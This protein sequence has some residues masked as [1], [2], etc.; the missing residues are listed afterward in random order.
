MQLKA[1]S[2]F[3]VL[4]MLLFGCAQPDKNVVNILNN[5]PI[6]NI[7]HAGSGFN[8]LM[9]PFNPLPP[10]SFA[11]LTNALKNGAQGVEVDLQI[12]SDNKLVLFHDKTT[13]NAGLTG[14]VPSV[15]SSELE[16]ASYK[17]GFPYDIF[18]DEKVI[19]FK[20]WISYAVKL[21][22]IPYLQIDVKISEGQSDESK[23]NLLQN[24]NR[25]LKEVSYPLNKVIVISGDQLMLKKLNEINPALELAFEPGE[26]ENG[27]KWA[28]ENNCKYLILDNRLLTSEKVKQSHEQGI[29]VI[30][31]G[32]KARSTL[33][34]VINMKPMFI[35][36]NHVGLVNELLQ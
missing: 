3:L 14:T 8:Y 15:N 26:F 27:L 7:G 36:S 16:G 13:E 4:L 30:A 1:K 23:L 17:I 22:E 10:N 29:G 20:H 12:T 11:S 5:Q 31:F 24:L 28:K 34:N 35:Q 25:E 32:G 6:I 9:M 18:Q 19:S 33:V 2:K 21:N